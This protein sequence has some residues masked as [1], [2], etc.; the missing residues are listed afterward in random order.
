MLNCVKVKLPPRPRVDVDTRRLTYVTVRDQYEL[1]AAGHDGSEP[2]SHK[3]MLTRPDKAVWMQAEDTELDALE[4]EHETWG[5]CSRAEPKANG[6]KIYRN[7]F[8]YAAKPALGTPGTEGDHAA[9]F[10]ARLMCTAWDEDITG[11]VTYAPVIRHDTLRAFLATCAANNLN[12]TL[13]CLDICNAFLLSKLEEP[14]YCIWSFRQASDT[15]SV[16]RM[17]RYACFEK[18]SMVFGP[19]LYA[20]SDISTS[21]CS[22]AAMALFSALPTLACTVTRPRT[23]GLPCMLTTPL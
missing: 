1:A 9:Q 15:M 7:K 19:H 14:M 11:K 20:S 18:E 4:F 17:A 2:T 8:V 21:F 10:K 5:Y 12:H 3:N 6:K 22:L 13:R 16:A 23:S